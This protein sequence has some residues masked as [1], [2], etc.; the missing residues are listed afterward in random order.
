[1][2]VGLG[3]GSEVEEEAGTIL[4]GIWRFTR[5]VMRTLFVQEA[6][7]PIHLL[8]VLMYAE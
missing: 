2:V 3:K 7:V 5:K 4:I 8:C 1:M 6:L